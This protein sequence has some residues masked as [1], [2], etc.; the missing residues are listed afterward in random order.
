M[1][2]ISRAGILVR[3]ALAFSYVIYNSRKYSFT[4]YFLGSIMASITL[5]HET[6]SRVVI[7][8]SSRSVLIRDMKKTLSDI[9]QD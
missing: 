7:K 6:H 8:K 3:I 1:Q 4:V 5:E 9:P 2:E